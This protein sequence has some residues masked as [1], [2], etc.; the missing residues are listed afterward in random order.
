MRD[1]D[2]TIRYMDE[3]E[4]TTLA[5]PARMAVPLLRSETQFRIVGE[6]F[7]V[8]G[9]ERTIGELVTATGSSQATVSREVARLAEAGILERRASGNRTLVRAND[10]AVI[11]PELRSMVRKLYGPVAR[12]RERLAGLQGVERAFVFGSFAR[13]WSGEAGPLPRDVD[14]MVIGDV[15]PDVIWSLAAD[16][17][18]EL[19][20]EVNPVLRTLEEWRDDPTG[21]AA[22][23]KDDVQID[24]VGERP[25]A[26]DGA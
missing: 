15:D 5:G 25:G 17:S 13:R 2:D 20:I 16:L 18:R 14:V 22:S 26:A 19:G 3:G 12:L 6:L 8:Q 4:V 11:A 23:V 21:F 9:V 10:Q 7:S 24:L 1:V